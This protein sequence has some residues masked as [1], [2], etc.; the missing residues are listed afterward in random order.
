MLLQLC[1]QYPGTG[2]TRFLHL[3]LTISFSFPCTAA[4]EGLDLFFP[5]LS[6]PSLFGIA[7][8]HLLSY[9]RHDD[10]CPLQSTSEYLSPHTELLLVLLCTLQ[11]YHCRQLVR[12][13]HHRRLLSVPTFLRPF[14]FLQGQRLHTCCS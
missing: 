13:A 2:S 4:L 3:F 10:T 11:K 14:V 6:L 8:H 5:M 7:L 1:R 12:R 9:G